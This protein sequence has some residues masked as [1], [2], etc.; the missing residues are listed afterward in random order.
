M[1]AD[2]SLAG[3]AGGVVLGNQLDDL[4][5]DRARL[6]F[7]FLGF[8]RFD[9]EL[10]VAENADSED[11]GG[12]QKSD[13]NSEES[14]LGTRRNRVAGFGGLGFGQVAVGRTAVGG[15]HVKG[16]RWKVVW[17]AR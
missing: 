9:G 16:E 7:G 4:S 15:T 17:E 12:R 10:E 1:R 11:E 3:D 5:F 8:F 6:A 14:S 2:V 13:Q